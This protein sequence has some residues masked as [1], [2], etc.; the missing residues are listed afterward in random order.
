M[1]TFNRLGWLLLG[2]CKHFLF[3]FFPFFKPFV[4]KGKVR[5][6]DMHGA[7]TCCIPRGQKT[8]VSSADWNYSHSADNTDT[9]Y[10]LLQHLR[11]CSWSWLDILCQWWTFC[12][13]TNLGSTFHTLT[14]HGC[15][16]INMKKYKVIF[17]HIFMTAIFQVQIMTGCVSHETCAH[18]MQTAY[19]SVQ[20]LLCAELQP[21]M[22]L[23]W[24]MT[25]HILMTNIAQEY[26][27]PLLFS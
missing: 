26:T 7:A 14:P 24:L 25:E 1:Q 16:K 18:W 13:V 5:P 10:T 4:Q 8:S 27:L 20:T 2:K 23:F 11:D 3:S 22:T 6:A 15:E 9:H 21:C 12:W 19:W 17:I